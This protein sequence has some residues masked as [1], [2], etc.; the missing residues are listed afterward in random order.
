MGLSGVLLIVVGVA[1]AVSAIGALVQARHVLQWRESAFETRAPAANR[2]DESRGKVDKIEDEPVR[3]V[4]QERQGEAG[5]TEIVQE[6]RGVVTKTA[7]IEE[8]SGKANA[9]KS[10]AQRF[11]D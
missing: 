7:L 8:I 11:F 3:R 1:S 9:S 6:R 2:G 10:D 5:E 4:V